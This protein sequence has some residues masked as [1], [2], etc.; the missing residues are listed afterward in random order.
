MKDVME[1][2]IKHLL[3]SIV[4]WLPRHYSKSYQAWRVF[5]IEEGHLATIKKQECM[6]SDGNPLPW[7]T[8][9]AID[10]LK[11]IDFSD[12]EVFEYGC[13]SSTLYWASRSKRVVAVEDDSGWFLKMEEIVPVNVELHL[14]H[15][16]QTYINAVADFS[17]GEGNKFDVI[18]VDGSWR[19][20]AALVAVE[21]L[22]EDG[23]IILD[24]AD[25]YPN[26]LQMLVASGLTRVDMIGF[27]P[28][29]PY[30]WD[31]ALFLAEKYKPL[32]SFEVNTVGTTRTQVEDDYVV[33]K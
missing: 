11:Q 5:S 28:I 12:K 20:D 32:F 21:Y 26:T 25:W 22:K 23:L 8:Y 16:R 17:H 30:K 15:D 14:I 2:I 4:R 6:D 29:N 31:T 18:V 24:N 3:H 19:N 9:P 27:G 13:G 1:N 33:A 7:Y 10:Y